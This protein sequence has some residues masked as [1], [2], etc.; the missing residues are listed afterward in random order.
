VRLLVTGG[1]GFVGSHYVRTLLAGGYPGY[2]TAEVTVLDA[3]TYAGNRANL[4]AGEG[5]FAF[6]H[7]D[8]ADAGLL[9]GVVPGHDAV[10]HFAAETFVDASIAG[11][12]P[13]VRTN[14]VGAQVL[15]DACRAA[16]V[17]R[18]VFVSTDEVYGSIEVGSWTEDAPL[19]PRSPY[20]ASKAGG[21]LLA[22][23]Y[24]I[25]YRLPVSITRC[26]NNYGPYQYP[27]KL[28]PLFVT[29]LIDGRPVPLYGDGLHVRDWLH[30]DDHCRGVQLVLERGEPGTA[31]NIGGGTELTNRELTAKLLALTGRDA[32][33]VRPVADRPGHD[34]RYSLDDSRLRALG[35]APRVD[36]DTGLA[37]TVRWYR[38]HERWWRPLRERAR[39]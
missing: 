25:T 13:F 12:A 17:G 5:R 6:V 30:V 2:E 7:G 36:L 19:L 9:A 1:A 33:H 8:V 14:V 28:V 27:E 23:A 10:V 32:G 26:S 39:R 35:Y 18:V 4:A 20:A 3:L 21:E 24:A 31:Y 38:E 29:N 34:R 16:G 37:E 22:R 15:L 11:P